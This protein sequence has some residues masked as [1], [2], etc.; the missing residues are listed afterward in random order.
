MIT[1]YYEITNNSF[2]HAAVG[3]TMSLISDLRYR[4]INIYVQLHLHKIPT[5]LFCVFTLNYDINKIHISYIA[6]IGNS[7]NDLQFL[8]F[9]SNQNI[10][11]SIFLFFKEIF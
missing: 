10:R 9:K 4:P 5:F 8:N 2:V 3:M 6:G 11:Y 1:D 7:P